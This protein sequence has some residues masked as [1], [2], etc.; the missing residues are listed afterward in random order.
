MIEH[1]AT[2]ADDS[3]DVSEE[4]FNKLVKKIYDFTQSYPEEMA[5]GFRSQL[6]ITRQRLQS[7]ISNSE[8]TDYP[9]PSDMVS[10]ILIGMIFSTSDYFHLV[11]TPAMLLIG[12]HL[13]QFPVSTLGD[14]ASSSLL[15]RLSLKYQT[16]SKR[17]V[18]EAVNYLNHSIFSFIQQESAP[19]GFP[20]TENP[21][22]IV[23]EGSSKGISIRNLKVSDIMTDTNISKIST[24]AEKQL[25]LSTFKSDLDSL[26][27][28][29]SLWKGK[30]AYKE[31]FSPSLA[32]LDTLSSEISASKKRS[33]A[34]GLI[35]E[36]VTESTNQLRRLINLQ[37]LSRKPL[38]LQ[39]HKPI[40]IPT[41]APKFEEN[42]SVDK[43][44][45]DPNV[46]R[47][48]ISKLK[49]QVKK[50]RKGA[51]RELRKDNAFISREKLAAK[52]K[53]DSDYH[54]MLARL[55]RNVASEG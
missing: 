29:A 5:L 16:L 7:A 48:E 14:Y 37:T 33:V 11:A 3:S 32:L 26:L 44:S 52:K 34:L 46:Q 54:A 13:S 19:Q 1:A 24:P 12:Q 18:P 30:D 9:L 40:P 38:M 45:Y 28:F 51:L 21:A 22:K 35:R 53:K 47:Q 8:V 50:E 55:E 25:V 41:Y 49:A 31:I 4:L 36:R 20:L 10:F 15:A 6:Q 17:Y 27:E 39:Q 42:Y 43:K 2:I 23:I